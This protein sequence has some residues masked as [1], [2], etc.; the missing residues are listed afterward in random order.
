MDTKAYHQFKKDISETLVEAQN[1]GL[2]EKIF[3]FAWDLLLNEIEKN[4]KSIRR[5]L[6]TKFKGQSITVGKQTI[7]KIDKIDIR[8]ADDRDTIQMTL[9]ISGNGKTIRIDGYT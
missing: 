7:E 1:T 5:V 2:N 6:N 9:I 3:Y 8:W 4:M